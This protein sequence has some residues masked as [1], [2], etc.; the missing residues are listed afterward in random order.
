MNQRL[1]GLTEAARTL[2]VSIHTLRRL[3]AHGDV[4]TVNVGTR[5]LISEAEVERIIQ[6]GVGQA[7]PARANRKAS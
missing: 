4:A 2:S 7:R 5:R 6:R 1:L 3:V